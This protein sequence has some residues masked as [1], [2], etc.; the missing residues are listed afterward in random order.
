MQ[1]DGQRNNATAHHRKK[2]S[3]MTNKKR[4]KIIEASS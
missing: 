2:N 1:N 3:A 4:S